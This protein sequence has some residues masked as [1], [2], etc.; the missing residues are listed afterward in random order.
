MGG[1]AKKEE[2]S[3]DELQE[4]FKQF[5]PEEQAKIAARGR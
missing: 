1:N 3:D 5:L 2:V 4:S